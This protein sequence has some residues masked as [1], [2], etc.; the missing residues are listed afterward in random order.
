[1]ALLVCPNCRR[2]LQLEAR[3]CRGCE[4][5]TG[6]DPSADA[7]CALDLATGYWCSEAGALEGAALCANSRYGV[8]NWLVTD[9]HPTGFCRSCRHNAIIPDL[10]A[11]G[12][13][14][15]WRRVESAKRRAIWGLLR[16]GLD[17]EGEPALLFHLLYDP[18][19]ETGGPPMHPTGY[20]EGVVTLN[21]VEADDAARE[22]IRVQMSEPYRTLVGHFRHELGHHFWRRLVAG[23]RHIEAF[24][25]LFGDERTDYSVAAA[26]YYSAGGEAW[27]SNFVSRY[28][29]MHPAEDF[30]ETFAHF[31]HIVDALAAVRDFD[32]TLRPASPDSDPVAMASDPYAASTAELAGTWPYFAF[33]LN[34]VNRSMGKPD[35]YPFGLNPAVVLKLDFVNR[36]VA[37]AAG[38]AAFNPDERP[39]LDAV[40]AVLT[41]SVDP[42]DE[43]PHAQPPWRDGAN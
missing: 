21:L 1:L 15:R 8:C 22:R 27:A 28:A 19:A 18:A 2:L 17:L 3:L 31:L 20:L 6:F 39:A 32:L 12:V 42:S 43:H 40:M 33:A 9:G 5:A 26:A 29:S 4:R 23:T 24:R 16:L 36:L 38:R 7:F 34:A 25:A 37:E 10:T 11:P 13:L 41:V 35:L 14:E 30:A